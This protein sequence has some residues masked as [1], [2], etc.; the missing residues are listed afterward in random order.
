M[1]HG[2]IMRLTRELYDMRMYP[3]GTRCR[4]ARVFDIDE[5]RCLINVVTDD[6]KLILNILATDLEPAE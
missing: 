3:K 4:V 5:Y 1:K 6:G 2:D